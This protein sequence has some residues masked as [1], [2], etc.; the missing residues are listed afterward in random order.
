M[1]REQGKNISLDDL[2]KIG[3]MG[4]AEIVFGRNQE[5][6]SKSYKERKESVRI[7]GFGFSAYTNRPKKPGFGEFL[8][9]REVGGGSV[10][11]ELLIRDIAQDEA[12]PLLS[13]GPEQAEKEHERRVKL[14]RYGFAKAPKIKKRQLVTA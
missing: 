11:Q 2:R 9:K 8:I 1:S 12:I 14:P 4:A 3:P 5:E 7:V 6:L 10:Y 13:L